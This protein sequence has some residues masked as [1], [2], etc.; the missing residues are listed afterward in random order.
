MRANIYYCGAGFGD[1]IRLAAVIRGQIERAETVVFTEMNPEFGWRVMD[2]IR[3]IDTI[4]PV[5]EGLWREFPPEA[6]RPLQEVA[7]YGAPLVLK[8]S[9]LR[10]RHADVTLPRRFVAVQPHTDL[11]RERTFAFREFDLPVVLVGSESDRCVPWHG[12]IDLRGVLPPEEAMW[13]VATAEETHGVD[14]WCVTLGGC[15]GKPGTMET[16]RE[17]DKIYGD[18]W[19]A[20]WPSLTIVPV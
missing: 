3:F 19:R 15:L 2:N 10:V 16:S 9:D 1:A 8:E 13:V 20:A 14:S 4:V 12:A 17:L 7:P 18:D 6:V 5:R 11:Y